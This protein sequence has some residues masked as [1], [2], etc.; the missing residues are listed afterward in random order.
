MENSDRSQEGKVRCATRCPQL[1]CGVDQPFI[2]W[3]HRPTASRQR[4]FQLVKRLSPVKHNVTLT[5]NHL[6]KTA[7]FFWQVRIAY[8]TAGPFSN[9]N[10][11]LQ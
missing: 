7:D 3:G 4:V 5:G 1:C 6:G 9:R 10:G 8:L 2:T 11:F